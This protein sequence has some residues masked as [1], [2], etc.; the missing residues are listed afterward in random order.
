MR[1][2]IGRVCLGLATCGLGLWAAA[3]PARAADTL[4]VGTPETT[5]FSMVVIDVGQQSGIFAKYGLD[6]QRQDFAGS[7]KL[8]PALAGGSIDLA[9]GSGSDF[10]FI[11]KGAPEKAVGVFQTLPNDLVIVVRG[12]GPASLAGLK[13]RQLGVAGPGG[14]MLWIGMSASQNEG[15]GPNGMKYVY[16]GTGA[17]IMAA[18]LSKNVDAAVAETG[19]GYRIEL[20]GRGKVIALGGDVVHPFLAHLA[21][22]S[23]D[24]MGKRPDVLRRYLKA[25][26]ETV[27]YTKTHE[28]ETL[29][30]SNAHTG[31][32]PEIGPRVYAVV[33]PQFTTDGHFEKSAFAATKQALIDLGVVK[34]EDMPEDSKLYTE[35]FLP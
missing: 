23:N 14:L 8:H 30:M 11:A 28:A 9:M 1:N 4:I 6:V 24:L 29:R 25:L 16:L 34:P 3:A 18:L 35:E 27:A 31:Y 2:R 10:L 20:E 32:S 26:Y 33:A 17:T 22:A 13:D 15:W 19:T 7:A 12:D 5:A 21:F